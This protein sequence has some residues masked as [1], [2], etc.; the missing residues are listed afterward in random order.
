[1][2]TFPTSSLFN[3][4]FYQSNLFIATCPGVN[5]EDEDPE[6][7]HDSFLKAYHDA[8]S[9]AVKIPGLQEF[10]AAVRIPANFR[11]LYYCYAQRRLCLSTQIPLHCLKGY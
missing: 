8:Q 4:E 7:L 9:E 3:N 1:M 6:I 11:V 2:T 5:E 10:A